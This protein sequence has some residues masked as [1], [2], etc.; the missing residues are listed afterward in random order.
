V[1]R[2]DFGLADLFGASFVA[3]RDGPMQNAYFRVTNDSGGAHPILKGLEDASIVIGGTWQVDVKANQPLTQVPLTWIPPVINL[4]MEKTYWTVNKT[5]IP[6]VYLRE[7]GKGRVVYFPWDIDRLYWEVM[8]QDHGTL[9]RNAVEWA[10]NEARP[11]EVT[12][13]GMFD[14]TVWKQKGSMTVHLV[15]LTNPMAMRPNMHELIPSPPQHVAVRLPQGAKATKVQLLV[16]GGAVPVEQSGGVVKL[17]VKSVLD[18]EVIA[19]DLA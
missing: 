11:V 14:V 9:L 5:D 13:L 7:A 3:L 10:T 2:R 19:I 12:G 8:A 15:N 16:A 18:H 6:G 1:Q 4:P 17:T